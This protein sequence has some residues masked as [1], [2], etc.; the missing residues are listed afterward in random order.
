M[1]LRLLGEHAP[2]LELTRVDVVG[3]DPLPDLDAVDGLLVTG[4][5]HDAVATDRWITDLAGLLRAAHR[6]NTPTV[7]ICFGHQLIA[8]ALGGRIERAAAGWG[9]G[10]HTAAL[11]PAGRDRFGP[12]HQ[13]ALLHSHQDQ[14]TAL[15]P[16]GRVLAASPHAP[17]A[18]LEVGSLL[19]FQGHPEFRPA[20]AAALMDSREQRIPAAVRDRAHA[21]LHETTQHAEVA[22]WIGRHLTGVPR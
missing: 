2:E 17:I 14:V 21:S 11:T 22:G 18:A 8:H 7:G 5:R 16:S 15:P 3:G 4:S 20:Y 13:V 6:R 19:G 12:P 1:F 10:V 9:V